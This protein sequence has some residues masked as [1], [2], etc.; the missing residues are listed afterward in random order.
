VAT[1]GGVGIE[2]ICRT[3]QRKFWKMH[4]GWTKKNVSFEPEDATDVNG[5]DFNRK[6]CNANETFCSPCLE[7]QSLHPKEILPYIH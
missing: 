5:S 2:F 7:E 3:W 4:S 1:E 6:T